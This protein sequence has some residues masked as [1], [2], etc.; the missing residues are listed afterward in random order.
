MEQSN[1]VVKTPPLNVDQEVDLLEYLNAILRFKYRI[2]I[3]SVLVA[4]AVFAWSK[5][6]DNR[7]RST[8]VVAVNTNQGFGG[9][10]AGQYRGSDIVGILEYS[11]MVDE[12]YD[13]EQSRLIARLTSTAFIELFIKENNLFEYIFRD[14][15]DAANK[16]WRDGFVPSMQLAVMAFRGD[17]L[18]ADIDGQSGLLP[19][20]IMS[21]Y[22]ELSAKLANAYYE[23]FNSYTRE[24]RL[25]ELEQQRIILNQRLDGTSNVEMQRSIYRMLET[26]LAEEIVL[27][28]KTDYPLELI[29]SAQPALFKSSPNRKMWTIV[30]F[31]VTAVLG[32]VFCIARIVLKKLTGALK[33]YSAPE[34]VKS[35]SD[36]AQ[37]E[38]TQSVPQSDVS[39]RKGNPE[40]VEP[41]S[42]TVDELDEWLD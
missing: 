36:A 6:I 22:P 16:Q 3:L 17:M 27:N 28:A 34:P 39:S 41:Q 18:S 26:Q 8:A 11:L 29:Q 19:I 21:V 42:S 15:W 31:I 32:V 5:T 4:G 1:V 10:R 12:P 2:L 20:T 25:S 13:N 23:R 33:Q 37:A 9:T 40:K 7:Y 30:S 38:A 24:K 14:Q 35:S